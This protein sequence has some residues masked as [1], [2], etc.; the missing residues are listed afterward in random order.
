MEITSNLRSLE[1]TR[2]PFDTERPSDSSF[3]DHLARHEPRAAAE[4]RAEREATLPVRRENTEATSDRAEPAVRSTEERSKEGSTLDHRAG[5]DQPEVVTSASAS[6]TAQPHAPHEPASAD[7]ATDAPE[8]VL[9]ATA[10]T[11]ARAH[12][13]AT[14]GASTAIDGAVIAPI[15]PALNAIAPTQAKSIASALAATEST[16]AKPAL[17]PSDAAAA[18]VVTEELATLTDRTGEGR[19]QVAKPE[20]P[21]L[22][23]N[24][25]AAL[26]PSVREL[27]ERARDAVH[28]APRTPV[29]E[30]SDTASDILKQVRLKLS[31]ELRQATLSLTPPELGRISIRLSLEDRR[32]TAWVRGEK[33]ETLE[34]L[35]KHLPE[36]RATLATHGIE[37]EH[38]ELALGFQDRE[39]AHG[40]PQRSPSTSVSRAE[41]S[42]ETVELAPLARA[43][44]AANG[45]DTFA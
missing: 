3:S 17:T 16:S 41:A 38:F 23:P 7:R 4:R 22:T 40:E 8:L 24:E 10:P 27:P 34:L 37:A 33:R 9:D 29:H 39:H 36:L 44:A 18:L 11:D 45:V 31:P 5:D 42:S 26:S 1:A 32:L 12:A 21:L 25:N 43:L 2:R 6:A 35:G 28:E 15:A 20:K 13:T 30:A 19:G 14:D